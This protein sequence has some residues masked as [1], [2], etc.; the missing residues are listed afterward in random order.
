MKKL[1]LDMDGTIAKFNSKK[2]ALE[3]FAIE[4]GF[5]ATLKPFK[6][7]ETIDKIIKKGEIQIF[8]ISASPNK[9]ADDDKILW[10]QTYLPN[11]K[12]ENIC[13][14]RLG[15]NKAKAI[16]DKLNITID[17]E[18]YLLDDYTKNLVEWE[19][20]NGIGIKRLTSFA[21]NSRKLWKGSCLKDL[22]QLVNVIKF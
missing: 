11:L 15:E 21:D 22:R 8:I 2:N 18:C 6:Y 9:Q 13:F 12:K 20:L 19:N 17:N 5:F 4:K 10:L 7:I 3:R 1:F 16:K 14:C